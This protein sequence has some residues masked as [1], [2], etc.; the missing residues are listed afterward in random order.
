V[1]IDVVV[2]GASLENAL[3]KIDGPAVA[4]LRITALPTIPRI[5]VEA[6][7]NEGRRLADWY[8]R[9]ESIRSG[10]SAT[11]DRDAWR[12]LESA[13]TTSQRVRIARVDSAQIRVETDSQTYWVTTEK[14]AGSRGAPARPARRE[15]ISAPRTQSVAR[16]DHITTDQRSG[17][18]MVVL[19]AV[20]AILVVAFFTAVIYVGGSQ[21]GDDDSFCDSHACIDNFDNGEGSIV[22]C[23]DG[24]WS[25]SGGLSGACSWHG[26]VG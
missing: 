22:Q 16:A 2:E 7:D 20:F 10:G 4:L 24:T 8:W 15:T 11:V 21:A 1:S 13:I 14:L 12:R 5:M 23:A 18:A 25:R 9:T 19:A 26:G 3:L 6:M 17:G